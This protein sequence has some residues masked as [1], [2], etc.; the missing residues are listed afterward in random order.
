METH[1]K[2]TIVANILVYVQQHVDVK[3]SIRNYRQPFIIFWCVNSCNKFIS[4]RKGDIHFICLEAQTSAKK[5]SSFSHFYLI[6]MTRQFNHNNV[7]PRSFH[8]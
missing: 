4:I 8:E 5:Q 3:N 7:K 1:E 6:E 2:Q